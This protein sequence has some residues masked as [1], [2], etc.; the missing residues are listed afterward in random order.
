MNYGYFAVKIVF[1]NLFPYYCKQYAGVLFLTNF[2][3]YRL[4]FTVFVL[5]CI[6]VT[7]GQTGKAD[8]RQAEKFR[9]IGSEMGSLSVQPHFLKN[10]DKFWFLYKTGEG[11]HYYFVDPAKREKKPLFDNGHLVEELTRLTS[12]PYNYRALPITDI[13]FEKNEVTFTFTADKKRFAYNTVSGVLTETDTVP[14]KE[15]INWGTYS[16]DSVY[17]LFARNHDLYVMRNGD[18]DS[19]EIRL[20]TD[21]ERFFSYASNERD[22]SS[23]RL[24]SRAQWFKDSKK[25]SVVRYDN[26]KVRDFWIVNMTDKEPKLEEY[27][28]PLPGDKEVGTPE[29]SVIDTG[30]WAKRVLDIGKWKDQGIRVY[31]SAVSR[32]SFLYF[33]RRKRTKDEVEIGVVD[34]E[35]GAV[36]VLIYEKGEPYL[37][38]QLNH[39]SI[40]NDGKDLIWWSE[41]TGWG[42]YYHYDGKSGELKNRITSGGNWVAGKIL[43]TDTSGRTIYFEGYDREKGVNPYYVRVYKAHIDRT[44]ETL[45]TPE[46]AQHQVHMPKSCRF[47]VDNYSRVDLE[48]RAVLRDREGKVIMELERPDL[49]RLYETGWQMPERF[50]V[51]AKDGVT[52]LYGVMWKPFDFDSTRTYPIISYVYPGPQMEAAVLAFSASGGYNTALA[53][54]GF[55]VVNFGHR[56]GSPYRDK[57]YHTYGYDN[58]RDYAL[59][60]DKYGLE[61][62]ADRYSFIDLT[63]VGIFGH[64]GGGFMSTAALCTYP[65]FY[66]AAVSSAG[67]HDNNIY[68][69]WW[70]ETHHGVKEKKKTVKDSVNG[71]REEITFTAKIPTNQE[72]VR[73]FKGHLLL[74][75]GDIDNNVH[76][77]NTLRMADALI[78]AGK[79]FDFVVLPGQR[80]GFSGIQ[81]QFYIRKMWFHFAKYLLG[82]HSS[83][84]F[85]QIDGFN[86][87]N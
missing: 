21:G 55:I 71:D 10:S 80:H 51:K 57:W 49:K 28:Y 56:G 42:H 34:T 82:D 70:G 81:Q 17:I 23:K 2:F 59:A 47:L 64:S 54:L 45:L 13:E 68:N 12:K 18:A 33:E 61:Q 24:R 35:T 19:T 58:L 44:G 9:L 75:T 39:L 76:P 41:R 60:D 1:F 8:Y 85:Y 4:F 3:M 5:F 15:R 29:L 14:K 77:G 30:S 53:Q 27:R 36:K 72:L 65:D 69:R 78:K 66:T 38:E 31:T 50:T 25:I 43:A 32:S 11:T 84:A 40:L 74:V 83:E 26:R 63:K 48:P 73:N 22:T 46:D 79:N 67:N 16:P 86:R 37:N 87:R 62:L 7:Y 6:S 20:T 52:D